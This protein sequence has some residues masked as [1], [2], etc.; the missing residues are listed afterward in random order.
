MLT[1][2]GLVSERTVAEATA[3]LLGLR[4]ATRADY[5]AEAILPDRLRLKFLRKSRAIPIGVDERTIVIAMADPLDRFAI[6]SIAI[7]SERDVDVRM[8]LPI[9]LDAAFDRLYREQETSGRA[10][11]DELISSA[12][13][14]IEDDAERLKDLASEAPVIRPSAS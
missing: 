6:S 13:T 5:P 11:I 9:D 3:H 2:L 10:V 12:A 8:A 1:Q 4:M 14:A 7:A